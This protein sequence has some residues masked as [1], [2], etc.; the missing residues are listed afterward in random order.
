MRRSVLRISV[1]VVAFALAGSGIVLSTIDAYQVNLRYILWKHHAWPYQRFMLSFLSVDGE[2]TMSLHG[3]TKE[4]MQRHFP[5]LIPADRAI[6]PYQ[7]WYSQSMIR[8]PKDCLWIGD[9]GYAVQ[10]E[11][12][13]VV[14]VGPIKG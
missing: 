1:L 9:S 10:F 13:K 2:F 7:K 6:T 5:L 14:Y 11:D 4:E 3:K 12:G 8:H